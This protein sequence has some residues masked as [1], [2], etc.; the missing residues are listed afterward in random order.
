[1]ITIKKNFIITFFIFFLNSC[2]NFEPLYKNQLSSLY[3]L[4]EVSII[5][6]K[7]RISENIKKNL[8]E[9]FP[10]NK[11]TKYILKIEGL[12]ETTA[13]VSDTARK[14]SRYKNQVSANIKIYY[15]QRKHDKLLYN[16]FEKRDASYSLI[17]NNVRSTMASKKS[18]ELT[19]TRLLSEEIYKRVLVFLSKN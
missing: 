10:N 17:S 7:K 15:R 6:D 11:K 1:M 13:T 3:A 16:F 18:A 5:T 2:S 4:Q 9:L 14:I 12:S 19:S 8:L